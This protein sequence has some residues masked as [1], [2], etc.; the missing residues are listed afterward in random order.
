MRHSVAALRPRSGVERTFSKSCEESLLLATRII[1]RKRDGKQMS[2]GEIEFMI[3]GMID[4]SVPDY[5]MSA[6]A[7]AILC[8]GMNASETATLTE[9]MLLTGSRLSRISDR[10]RVDKHSTGGLGDKVSLILAPLL[11]CCDLEIPMLSGRGLG[12][13]GG[14]LDKLE[15]YAGFRCDLDDLEIARQLE[16]IGCVITGTTPSIAPA[17][18]KLYSL[19]DVTGT[20]PSIPLI[21]SSILSKK[22]AENL[23]ALV[24]DVKFGS[25]AFMKSLTHARRLARSLE[26]TSEI[27]GLKSTSILSDMNQPLG[28]MIGNACEVNES[29][30]VLQGNGPEDVRE[31]TLRLAAELLVASGRCRD[32]EEA[33]P[34]L[35]AKLAS[36][37]A[38]TRYQR[39]IELQGGKFTD[40]LSLEDP[41]PVHSP[42]DGWIGS[43]DGELLGQTIIE[44]E[45]GRRILRD[46]LNHRVGIEILV[47]V[48]D[49]VT[50]GQP[51]G[52]LFVSNA[53]SCGL[54]FEM[55]LGAFGISDEPVPRL[56]LFP[57]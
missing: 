16:Q 25:G 27:L 7:M 4:G 56:S 3:H 13:T 22:L 5:Q 30:E 15:S 43:V 6:W 47:R 40:W 12:I 18:R 35:S 23:D 44:L 45:G 55:L 2:S 51:L 46:Q 52:R 42:W 34:I 39:M 31:L 17:D 36:G 28:R 33:N 57:D 21:T 24:F 32:K 1:S 10:P 26:E 9:C 50:K 53:A 37:E 54:A 29:V 38:L 49:H 11:A 41:Q 20:V 19:R 8:R 48:G 14:T